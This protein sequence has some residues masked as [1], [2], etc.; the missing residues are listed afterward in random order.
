[1]GEPI[2]EFEEKQHKYKAWVNFIRFSDTNHTEG[3]P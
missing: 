2:K 3:Y 1:M